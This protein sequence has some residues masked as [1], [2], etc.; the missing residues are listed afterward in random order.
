ML[1][2]LL[3]ETLYNPMLNAGRV[4]NLPYGNFEPIS[5]CFAFRVS[6]NVTRSLCQDMQI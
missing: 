2:P 1:S 3:E 4:L 5:E 6:L